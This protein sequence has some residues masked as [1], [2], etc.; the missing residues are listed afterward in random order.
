MEHRIVKPRNMRILLVN[1]AVSTSYFSEIFT[2]LKIKPETSIQNYFN[3]LYKGLSNSSCDL[4]SLSERQISTEEKGIYVQGKR[5]KDEYASYYYVPKILIPGLSQFLSFVT[6]FF[7]ALYTI[8]KFN[9]DVIICDVMRFY[10]STPS[11][12]ASRILRKKC[13]GYVADLPQMYNHQS[14]TKTTRIQSFFKSLYSLPLRFYDGYILLSMYMNHMVN[15]NNKPNIILEG[16]TEL[17][18]KSFN[19]PKISSHY[20]KTTFMYAGGLHEK[21]GVRLLIDAVLRSKCDIELWLF[22]KGDQENYLQQISSNR[23]KFFG[24]QPRNFVIQKQTEVDFLINPRFT[25]EEYTKYSFPSKIMEYMASGT[26]VVTTRV[27]GIPDDYF[28]YLIPIEHEDIEGFEQMFKECCEMSIEKRLKLG[29]QA[30]NYVRHNKNCNVQ[31]RRLY[32][33]LNCL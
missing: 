4:F 15:P 6:N 1:C 11:L 29:C 18:A 16:L 21:Y 7:V 20:S 12:L 27:K 26:P 17:D 3:L 22:G 8:I 2:S 32:T 28:K 19:P 5:D 30:S 14:M 13:I 24:Y 23:I 33:W 25:N 9:P 31:G 10:I